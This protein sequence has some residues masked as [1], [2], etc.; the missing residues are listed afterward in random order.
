MLSIIL[1][2]YFACL[3][4]KTQA[5]ALSAC[6]RND[7]CDENSCC[8]FRE[9]NNAGFCMPTRNLG[10]ICSINFQRGRTFS[11]GCRTGLTCAIV[12]KDR[13]TGEEKTRCVQI[14]LE[15]IERQEKANATLSFKKL[16]TASELRKKLNELQENPKLKRVKK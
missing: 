1:W 8:A 11:C 9:K 6:I 13:K 3:L 2:F 4:A 10:D 7:D 14:P 5:A 12:D 15:P 16:Y